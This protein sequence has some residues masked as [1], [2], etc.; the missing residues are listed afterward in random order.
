MKTPTHRLVRDVDYYSIG[1][2][3]ASPPDGRLAAGTLVA[4]LEEH[5]AYSRVQAPEELDVFVASDALQPLDANQAVP[6][7]EQLDSVELTYGGQPLRLTKSPS[8]IGIKMQ[9][10][11]PL[12]TALGPDNLPNTAPQT[13]GGFAIVDVEHA[14]QGME[15]KLDTLRNDSNVAAGT[16]VF[17]TSDDGVPF[18][19][20]GQ[21]YIEFQPG[22]STEECQ[23]LLDEQ[24]LTIIEAR[25][26]RTLIAQ[27]TKSSPNPIKAAAN[28]QQS[29]LVAVAE[30]DLATPSKILRLQLP[31][32]ERLV[33]QWHLRNSGLHHGTAIGFK[34]GADARVIDAWE[35]SQSLGDIGVIVAVIDDG[36]D[37]SHP[38]LSGDGKIVAAMDFTRNTAS[39]LPDMVARNWHGTACAGVA[40]GSANGVGILGAAPQARLMPVRWGDSLSDAQVESWFNYVAAMGAWVVSCS[41]KATAKVYTLSTRIRTAITNCARQGRNGLGTIV[42]F[43]AGNDNTDIDDAAKITI[44]GFATHPEVMAIAASTSRDERSDYSNFGAQISVCAPSSGAGGWRITTADVQ[45]SY[46]TN[47]VV[48]EAGYS[49]GAYTNEFGGTSSAC[50]LVAGVCAWLFSLNPKITA[51]ELRRAVESTARKIGSPAN[52]DAY[53][54]SPGYG[55][56]C[57]DAAAAAVALK[58]ILAALATDKVAQ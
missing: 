46:T 20:T 54:H 48:R 44:N 53:G 27:T 39:P 31:A 23:Q 36:F 49:P 29:P 1:P 2:Q 50:P 24:N 28:L 13:L 33:D 41:W 45:G 56:G 55:F 42:C 19:P 9:G 4:M 6:Q 43:A 7:R 37:L 52:Y 8:L 12:K 57:V 51:E 3:Q 5:P 16:H 38:D 10:N 47:G 40:V 26:E 18:L 25:G 17:H 34:K 15:I 58:G 14:K 11:N 21:I 22:T 35:Q 30:P 32:D